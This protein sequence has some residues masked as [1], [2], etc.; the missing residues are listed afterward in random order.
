MGGVLGSTKLAE[1]SKGK[2]ERGKPGAK[3]TLCFG[4]EINQDLAP[5]VPTFWQGRRHLL[6]SRGRRMLQ[7]NEA[8]RKSVKEKKG[9]RTS[10][11]LEV[12]T[13]RLDSPNREGLGIQEGGRERLQPGTV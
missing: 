5:L 2:N 1:L 12:R 10:R 3:Q 9:G 11:N 8:R 13:S 4:R 7:R 6:G